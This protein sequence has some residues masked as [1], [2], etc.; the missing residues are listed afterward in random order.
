MKPLLIFAMI[1][2]CCGLTS[3]SEEA[4][5]I[6]ILSKTT[7]SIE[8]HSFTTFIKLSLIFAVISIIIQIILSTFGL[9]FT[10]LISWIIIALL[11]FMNNKMGFGMKAGFISSIVVLSITINFIFS[12]IWG[13][14]FGALKKY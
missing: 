9:P 7:S 1:I 11:I 2:I 6:S 4:K 14:L 5:F 10:G 13:K 12:L 8:I 3:C